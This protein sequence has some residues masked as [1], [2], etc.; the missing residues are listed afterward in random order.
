MHERTAERTTCRFRV[1]RAVVH[2]LAVGGSSPSPS[3]ASSHIYDTRLS[4]LAAAV[5]LSHP[6][7]G[8]PRWSATAG[9]QAGGGVMLC[10]RR[11][12]GMHRGGKLTARACSRRKRSA[13]AHAVG[14]H[15][16]WREGRH[17]YSV[18]VGVSAQ[19]RRCGPDSR[20]RCI[21]RGHGG[22]ASSAGTNHRT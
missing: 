4:L 16:H 3:Q 7:M 5:D 13:R 10:D 2:I 22:S 1:G 12:A 15:V 20:E 6:S 19:S 21:F 17:G 14:A 11:W 18:V 9:V 8:L